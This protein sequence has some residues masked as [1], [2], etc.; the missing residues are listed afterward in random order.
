MNTVVGILIMPGVDHVLECSSHSSDD[1]HDK[2]TL[3]MVRSFG[4]LPAP[5]LASALSAF[6]SFGDPPALRGA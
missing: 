2:G 4:L 5:M 6:T 1:V 3:D